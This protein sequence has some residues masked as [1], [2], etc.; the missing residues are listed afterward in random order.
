[1]HP[2]VILIVSREVIAHAASCGGRQ[3]ICGIFRPAEGLIQVLSRLP[4]PQSVM[5]RLGWVNPT[6]SSKG[7]R[8]EVS[9]EGLPIVLE[10]EKDLPFPEEVRLLEPWESL[11]DRRRG[12]LPDEGLSHTEVHLAGAGSLGSS[13]GL[14]LAQAGVGRIRA[15]DKDTLG[16][17]NLSRHL[18]DITDLGREKSVA[19]AEKLS[20]RGCNA[21]GLTVDLTAIDDHQIDRLLEPAAVVVA[22]TDCAAAQFLV[23][24]SIL[25]LRKAAVFVGAW[26][27]AAGGE[28][29]VVRPGAG[30]CLFCATGFR[31]AAAPDV[32]PKERRQAYQSA[33]RHRLVAEPGLGLDIAYL[34]TI[35]SAHALALLDPN[36]SRASLLAHGGFTL[37]HG[38]SQPR[39][40][41]AELFRAPLE[42]VQARV[43][44]DEPC[45]VC[46][47]ASV[48][49][50]VS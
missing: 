20:L 21:L 25:R 30:P 48:K 45:P 33:D 37:L 49:E 31:A 35:A 15:Y 46:G 38:P 26:E 3:P 50:S 42:V 18:C 43:V 17:P 2:K 14:L 13:I 27:S 22:S 23:N 40:S 7:F 1:M 32:S 44:R 39:G 24:E 47:F 12:L 4:E 6:G 16:T 34:A 28:V 11:D 5:R 8:C 36:G 10:L 9:V 29:I 19:V 41:Y